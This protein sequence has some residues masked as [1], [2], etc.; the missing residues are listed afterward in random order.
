[1]KRT[2]SGKVEF[3][4]VTINTA[5]SLIEERSGRKMDVI[6]PSIEDKVD[7]AIEYGNVSDLKKIHLAL[8]EMYETVK[9]RALLA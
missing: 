3:Y 7:K 4:R 6:D 1:M 8:C 2:N 9:K 5:I